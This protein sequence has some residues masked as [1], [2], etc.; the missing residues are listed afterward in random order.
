MKG[1]ERAGRGWSRSVTAVLICPGDPRVPASGGKGPASGREEAGDQTR[2]RGEG[3]LLV[4]CCPCRP[5]CVPVPGKPV[6]R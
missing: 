3:L 1:S 4:T 6:R 5:G 2:M